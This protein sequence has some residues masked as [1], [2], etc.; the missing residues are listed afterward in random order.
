[1]DP[2]AIYDDFERPPS[3]PGDGSVVL[4]SPQTWQRQPLNLIALSGVGL[5]PSV[6]TATAEDIVGCTICHHRS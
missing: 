6:R 1:M 5:K 3:T 2:P 4:G